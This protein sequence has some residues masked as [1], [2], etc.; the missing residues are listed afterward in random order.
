MCSN[1]KDV[2]SVVNDIRN[3]NEHDIA[4]KIASLYL[5]IDTATESLN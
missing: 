4:S 5:I 2:W 1:A 3:E